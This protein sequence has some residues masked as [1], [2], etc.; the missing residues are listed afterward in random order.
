VSEKRSSLQ[1][2][3]SLH[4]FGRVRSSTSS[5]A[6]FSTPP[7]IEGYEAWSEEALASRQD[8]HPANVAA[9]ALLEG[10]EDATTCL[11]SE[12]MA[13][14]FTE[15]RPE[16]ARVG[17]IEPEQDATA[18]DDKG[19]ATRGGVKKKD[20]VSE[21]E[22][23]TG[24]LTTFMLC[25]IPCRVTQ[26]H[27]AEV[28]NSIGFKDKYDFLYLPSGGRSTKT[29]SNLGY[30]FINFKDPSYVEPFTKEFAAHRFEC[31]TSQ[32]VC[33]V[34]PAHVQG[35][36]ANMQNFCQANST[37]CPLAKSSTRPYT[38]QDPVDENDAGAT[39]M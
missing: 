35:F 3:D 14:V 8:A 28:I 17:G 25:N 22:K 31:T 26:E 12:D 32:K 4:M 30:G 39:A 7:E 6:G 10:S 5:T 27:L 16:D 21:F 9:A 36:E 19:R 1:T 13:V 20:L 11:F 37:R 38:G 29:G 2:I 33:T 18:E 15:T 23:H 34:K 24:P